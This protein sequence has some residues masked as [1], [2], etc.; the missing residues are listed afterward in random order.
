MLSGILRSRK[1]IQVNIEIM[2][3]FVQLR[4]VLSTHKRL[5]SKFKELERKVEHHDVEIQSIFQAIEEMIN[6]PFSP[7]KKIG[8]LV[9]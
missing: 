7:Q 1:A 9:D 4:Q 6:P 2:R 5:A 8:F 3:A